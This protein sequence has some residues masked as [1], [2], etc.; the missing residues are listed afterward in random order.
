ML[1]PCRLALTNG[2]VPY[3][4]RRMSAHS[5]Y[6][7]NALTRNYR[8]EIVD[9]ILTG[10]FFGTIASAAV[11]TFYGALD[12]AIGELR[13]K[14]VES[15]NLDGN[16]VRGLK[17]CGYVAGK[18][19]LGAYVGFAGGLVFFVT[20]PFLGISYLINKSNQPRIQEEKN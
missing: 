14:R 9:H 15:D 11:G 6:S 19:L 2:V 18:T 1:A 17:K 4:V 5:S 13:Y 12:G 16:E 8:K 10:I 7:S 20:S 3:A